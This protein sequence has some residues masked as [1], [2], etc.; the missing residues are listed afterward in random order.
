MKGCLL[1]ESSICKAVRLPGGGSVINGASLFSLQCMSKMFGAWYPINQY[2]VKIL[3][4][5]V[6]KI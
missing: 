6:I 1:G 3:L 2:N 5:Y 4:E